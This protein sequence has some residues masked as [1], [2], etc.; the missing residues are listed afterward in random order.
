MLLLPC[1]S[2]FY[3]S[4]LQPPRAPTAAV[5]VGVTAAA[6]EATRGEAPRHDATSREAAPTPTVGVPPASAAADAEDRAYVD[7]AVAEALA[8]VRQR[9]AMEHV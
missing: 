8:R 6:G 4:V 5:A 3:D 9:L 1:S 7:A 2:V